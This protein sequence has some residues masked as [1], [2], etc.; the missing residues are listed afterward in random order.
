MIKKQNLP[1]GKDGKPLLTENVKLKIVDLGNGCWGHHHFSSE[2]Q[3][4]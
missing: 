3:T 1:L 4:R 2:I